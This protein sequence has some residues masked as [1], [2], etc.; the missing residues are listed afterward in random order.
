A[1]DLA[2]ALGLPPKL[3]IGDGLQALGVLVDGVHDRLD[4]L[5]FAF[6]A[7]SE[8]AGDQV[9]E[10]GIT[11]SVQY[12][13]RHVIGDGLGDEASDRGTRADA[14]PDLGGRDVHPAC[15]E[16]LSADAGRERELF[17]TPSQDRYADQ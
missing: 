14:L 17:P 4:A 1:Y 3:I 15:F 16:H 11:L 2:E 7:R 8:D 9:L 5:A 6:V 10:H 12:V 13:L